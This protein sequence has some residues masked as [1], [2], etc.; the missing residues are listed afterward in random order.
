MIIGKRQITTPRIG[1]VKFGPARIMK[2]LKLLLII[3]FGIILTFVLLP[4]N[5][6][7]QLPEIVGSLTVAVFIVIMFSS[8]AYYLNYYILVI[9]GIMFAVSELLWGIYGI[10]IGPLTM[11]IFGCIILIVGIISFSQFL[12][13]Y[14][15]PTK[16]VASGS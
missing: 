16:E 3:C 15:L 5:F 14:P 11:L 7:D 4:I 9:Y 12:R 8:M 1:L 2:R 10:P 13:K 6:I